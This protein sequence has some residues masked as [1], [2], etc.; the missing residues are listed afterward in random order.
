MSD[1]SSTSSST[2][3]G[4]SGAGGGSMIRLTGM[5][6][7]LDV[8]GTVKKMLAGDQTKIDKAKQDQ[9]LLQWKQDAYKKII[10]DIKD[11]QNIY[12]DVTSSDSLISNTNYSS[13]N[14]TSSASTIAT[15]TA[16][17]GALEGNYTLNVLRLAS[18]ATI[19]GNAL[20]SQAKISTGFAGDTINITEGSNNVSFQIPSNF[21]GT[22]DDAVNLLNSQLSSKGINLTTSNDNG[23][24][25]LVSSDYVNG[26]IINDTNG[27][28]TSN[29]NGTTISK[30]TS[31]STTLYDNTKLVS[32]GVGDKINITEGAK[33][34]SIQIPNNF[35]SSTIDDTV[36]YLNSQFSSNGL[37]LNVVNDNGQLKFFNSD[38]NNDITIDDT[39][40]NN[41][42]GNITVTKNL[43][44]EMTFNN[45][46]INSNWA[47]KVIQFQVGTSAPVAVDFTGFTGT[48][49]NDIAN[50]MNQQIANTSGLNGQISVSTFSDDTGTYLRFNA[51]TNGVKIAASSVNDPSIQSM[52]GKNIN[53][54]VSTSTALTNLDSTLNDNIHLNLV[55]NGTTYNVTLDNSATGKNG[56]AK[57]SDLAA[58]IYQQTGG[59]INA[60]I[61]DITGKLT[62]KSVKTGTSSVIELTGGDANIISA[63]G[64]SNVQQNVPISG[65]DA[66]VA[67]TP[68]GSSVATTVTEST[69]KFLL[70]NI[71]YSLT[72]IGTTSLTVASDTQ[73]V[74]D[75]FSAFLKKYNSVVDEI[76]AKLNEKK[77]YDYK[78]LT[79]AQKAQMSDSEEQAWN[80]KAQQGVLRNDSNLQTLLT[81]MRKIFFDPVDQSGITFNAKQ[82]GLDTSNDVTKAG[83]INFVSGGQEVF[84][85]ALETNGLDIM[86]LFNATSSIS[87]LTVTNDPT[88]RQARYNSEGIMQR[89]SDILTDNVG[90]AQTTS[91]SAI[92]SKYANY[93]DDYSISGGSGT[94]TIPDQLYTQSLLLKKLT[95]KMSSDSEKYYKQFSQLET[96][97]NSLNSQQASLSAMLGNG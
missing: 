38:S 25:K 1:V 34:V 66:M 80:A 14:V 17:T 96:I 43:G 91:T 64:L 95:D 45:T 20:N 69:N 36:N 44:T 59:N 85:Q 2:Y 33:N 19:T 67:I 12:F 79:D 46:G 78:P 73:K 49:A 94:N 62:L 41:A 54:Q 74:V 31:I 22:I 7:G 15:A 89:L 9:Q 71:N 24:L 3:T 47:G 61:D 83:E 16:N 72:N 75:R 8:D 18:A 53:A 77:N 65:T 50:Y 27:V 58:A 37:S 56:G 21:S 30:P 81:N 87:Y 88:Q 23:K 57:I 82:L 70:N 93:Q 97:M 76:S 84:K 4:M 32:G 6:S 86:N 90:Y 92:L 39:G 42:I 26:I 35:D 28:I 51:L 68:P 60:S 29:S 48:T 40:S 55:Y 63:L 5:A 10:S 11:L 13:F 52:I